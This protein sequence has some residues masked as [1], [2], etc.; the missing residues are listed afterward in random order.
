LINIKWQCLQALYVYLWEV[1]G[2]KTCA[3]RVQGRRLCK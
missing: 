3:N 1:T 2:R